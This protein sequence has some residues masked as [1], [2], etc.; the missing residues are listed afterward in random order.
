M[1]LSYKDIITNSVMIVLSSYVK[2]WQ[3]GETDNIILVILH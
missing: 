2:C 3:I 1:R